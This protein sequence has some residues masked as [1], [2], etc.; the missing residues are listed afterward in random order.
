MHILIMAQHYAPEAVSGAV[1]AT[2]LATDLAR[3][4]HRVSFVTCTPNYPEGR[5]YKGYKNRLCQ[6]TES[7]G[8]RIVRTW[9]YISPYK[10]FWR[11]ILNYGTFS[12]TALY[13]GLLVGKP[14]VI[15]SYS[16]PLPLGL[17]AWL[18]SR[19]WGIPWVLRVEDLYPDAAIAAGVLRQRAA[20]S[21]FYAIE[22]LLY[23]KATHI[24]LISEGFRRAL[25]EKGVSPDKMSVM[26]VWADPDEVRPL[27][28][29]NSFRCQYGLDGQFVVMYAG[30]LGL[31]S[32]LEDVLLAA[33][34]LREHADVRFVIVGEGAKKAELQETA[35]R[36]R[37][38]NVQF[39]PF[40]PRE[41]F[42]EMLAAADLGL[43]T[44]NHAMARTSLPCK[45]F[46][47]MA[48][49]RPILA[50]TPENSEVADLVKMADCGVNIPPGQ[51]QAVATTILELQN[52]SRLSQMG[53]AGR[54]C[55]ERRF[56]R[57]RC[58]SL[59][60]ALLVRAHTERVEL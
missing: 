19:M 32:A 60:E 2:E 7:E 10:T 37:L 43:V 50:V 38:H 27:P 48:S 17:S 20:I 41:A 25:L 31:T 21:F 29:E 52:S 39:L 53:N 4:G 51:P 42:A 45:T 11:R 58:V 59:F 18:L 9:S 5:V 46:S 22:R 26:P 23:R 12:A 44:L 35:K 14:D 8:V 57:E 40:Q 3:L 54:K 30:N 13:G 49:G 36:K 55:L 28:R 47:I 15:T 1:L 24:S 56:S 16:P 33:E 6:V 34:Q